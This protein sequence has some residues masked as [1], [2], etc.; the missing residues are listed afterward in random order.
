[1]SGSVIRHILRTAAETGI[2]VHVIAR[3]TL[4]PVPPGADER[5]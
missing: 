2:D 4:P 3:S 5:P 1:M